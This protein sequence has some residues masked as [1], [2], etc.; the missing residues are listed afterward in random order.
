MTKTIRILVFGKVQGVYFRQSTLNFCNQLGLTGQ[1][2]NQDDGSVE[3][4]ATGTEEKIQQ[5]LAWSKVGPPKAVVER[6][7]SEEIR[8]AFFSGFTIDR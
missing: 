3:I 2:K 7:H 5:L 8:V 6:V 1:V 4:L